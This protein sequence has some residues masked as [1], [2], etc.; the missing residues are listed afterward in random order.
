[1]FFLWFHYDEIYDFFELQKWFM[2]F[3]CFLLWSILWFFYDI[4]MI[5]LNFLSSSYFLWFVWS[6]FN[7]R[8]ESS[9]QI[10][11]F[12]VFWGLI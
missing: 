7:L 11:F 4:F 9:F 8:K 12:V 10:A 3:L 2:I 1:M 6:L 5:F